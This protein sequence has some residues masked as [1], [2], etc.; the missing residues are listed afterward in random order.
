M[1][2]D[3]YDV[4]S[5]PPADGNDLVTCSVHGSRRLAR[6]CVRIPVHNADRVVVGYTHKC[7][8]ETQCAVSASRNSFAKPHE[9]RGVAERRDDASLELLTKSMAP[10][11]TTAA[12]VVAATEKDAASQQQRTGA[13]RVLNR[14]YDLTKQRD[15]DAAGKKKVC[16][17]CG[18]EGHEKPECCNTLCKTCHT[19]RGHHHLCQEPRPSPF[20]N[21]SPTTLL[22][23]DMSS[24]QCVSCSSLGHFDCSTPRE[25]RIP[26]CCFCG[27]RGHNAYDC[28]RRKRRVPDRWVTRLKEAEKAMN[29][30]DN[31][32]ASAALPPVFNS[33][34]TVQ[35]PR[36]YKQASAWR[37]RGASSYVANWNTGMRENGS[38]GGGAN[39][40]GYYA[41]NSR[42]Y[43]DRSPHSGYSGDRYNISHTRELD[44]YANYGLKRSRWGDDEDLS[45]NKH[46]PPNRTYDQYHG[47]DSN[48][49]GNQRV[50]RNHAGSR[51]EGERPHVRQSYQ[52]NGRYSQKHRRRN[53]GGG[54]S[55]DDYENLF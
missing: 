33:L 3:R 17:N 20:L 42:F 16:W 50:G 25:T 6:F 41:T 14:Y 12:G 11:P 1:R 27:E 22:S 49:Q 55:D 35:D 51:G 48:Q 54:D 23:E 4:A 31:C 13:T 2:S 38:Y 44:Q 28:S 7:K 45:R 15:A 26:S 43:N 36:G 32:G 8:E 40:G 47:L 39:S 9:I 53:S 34:H 46:H 29:Y 19:I 37:E 30:R 10:T 5:T 18:M 24:V 52:N 21:L